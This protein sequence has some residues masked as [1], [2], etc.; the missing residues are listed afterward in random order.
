MTKR[1]TT[2]L[3]TAALILII[4]CFIPQ[5]EAMANAG[6]TLSGLR[7]IAVLLA[8][9]VT[10]ITEAAPILISCLIFLGIMPLMGVSTGFGQALSGYTNPV[11]FFVLASYGMAAAF[12]SVPLPKRILRVLLR[13]FGKNSNAIIFAVM[14]CTALV[15]SI[16]SNVPNCAIFMA[17]SLQILEMY[18]EG[19]ARKKA[20]RALMLAVPVATMIGGCITPAGSSVSLM[21][22]SMLEQYTGRTISFIQW[23]LIGLPFAALTLPVSWYL[24][25]RIHKP[26]TVSQEAVNSFING[27]EIPRRMDGREKRV[28]AFFALLLALFLI[29]SWVRSINIMIVSVLGCCLMCLP[30]VRVLDYKTFYNSINW[31]SIILIGTVL[32]MGD[33][34]VYNGV[35]VWLTSLMPVTPLPVYFLVGLTALLSFVLLVIIPVSLSLVTILTAPL[36]ALAASSGVSPELVMLVCGICGGCCFLLPLDVVPLLT[37]G[38]GYYS[39]TDCFKSS[40]PIQVWLIIIMSVLFPVAAKLIGWI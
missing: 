17:L 12:S 30:F 2:G 16:L 22:I 18:E 3:I 33:A 21:A 9:L 13:R 20:G 31:P 23:T 37:Y 5:T 32:S 27:L 7:T 10:I 15:S 1:Q 8:F 36:I 28:A 11:V 6:L 24:I 38:T 39:M 40:A 34:I 19:E 35:S 4:S 29:S 26:P 14:L 25:C